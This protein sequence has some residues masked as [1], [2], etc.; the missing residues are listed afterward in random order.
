MVMLSR[1][2][3]EEDVLRLFSHYFRKERMPMLKVEHTA[4]LS[5]L[6]LKGDVVIL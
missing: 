6:L 4:T 3:L 5:R 1:L 2:L